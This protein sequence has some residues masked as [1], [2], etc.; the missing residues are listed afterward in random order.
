[1][2][3]AT[4]LAQRAELCDFDYATVPD[5]E[6]PYV[7]NLLTPAEVKRILQ[8][9]V[10][11]QEQIDNIV[12]AKELTEEQK[13]LIAPTVNYL[14][15]YLQGKPM[16]RIL[17]QTGKRPPNG[18]FTSTINAG[19]VITLPYDTPIEWLKIILVH[20]FGHYLDAAKGKFHSFPGTYDGCPAH[21]KQLHFADGLD[22][23][24]STNLFVKEVFEKQLEEGIITQQYMDSFVK[25]DI[26]M[27]ISSDL[28]YLINM[29]QDLIKI[30]AET[31]DTQT[32]KYMMKELIL[33][34]VAVDRL[35]GEIKHLMEFVMEQ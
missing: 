31:K 11:P 22:S 15:Q 13:Q 32:R 19:P 26:L 18:F 20:E 14:R 35:A 10:L 5:V 17:W 6:K 28:D 30:V 16:P 4:M 33:V 12:F 21:I 23:V 34:I 1:M 24:V 7:K 27:T 8:S 29:Q 2:F 3:Y 25:G 9:N